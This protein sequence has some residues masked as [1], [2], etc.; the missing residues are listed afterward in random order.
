[1]A[2]TNLFLETCALRPTAQRP[3]W[4]MRQ[5]GRHLPEYNQIR[6]RHSFKE[7]AQTPELCVQ[8]SLQP[9]QRYGLD[10]AIVFSDILVVLEAL[11]VP[12]QIVAGQGPILAQA[13][14]APLELKRLSTEPVSG[15]LDYVYSALQLLRG[16]LP[17]EVAVLGF[18]GAPW[19]LACYLTEG[20]SSK[21]GFP[22]VRKLLTR[23][24]DLFHQMMARL[25]EA[26]IDH[27]RA[28]LASG[29]DAVQVFDSWA[30][31]LTE[32]QFRAASLPYLRRIAKMLAGQRVI[33]FLK[34]VAHF[35]TAEEAADFPILS[36]DW[37]Q[38]LSFYRQKLDN[39]VVLQGNLDPAI[40]KTDPKT[41]V[42]ETQAVLA[43]HGVQP[44]H[45]FN[46]GHGL[47]PDVPVEHV[48]V[49]IETVKSYSSEP[50][51]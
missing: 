22:T 5:A 48:Q 28:Q 24:P 13:V 26:V 9:I 35:L 51:G 10:A 47:P 19:T 42:R 2:R 45:I 4:L 40:L 34:G 37:T 16:E 3:V 49:M 38:P 17:T 44:G 43:S 50:T 31:L 23:A 46:L 8:V 33:F 41:I 12:Y 30:G 25:T 14:T 15:H 7:V 39:E 11:G 27:L 32:A 21:E 29:A 36:V 6:Q 20:G 18:A 1:M